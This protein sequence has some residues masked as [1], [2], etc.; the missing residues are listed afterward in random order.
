MLIGETEFEAEHAA[1]IHSHLQRRSGERRGRLERGHQHAEQLFVRNAW[2]ALTNN[3]K[4][5]H[6]EYEIVDWRG[7]SYFI[8][9]VWLPGYIKLAIEI[10]GFGPHVTEMDRKRYSEELNRETF[11]RAMGFHVI[12]FSYD[13]VAQRPDLCITLLR[14]VMSRYQPLRTT[15]KLGNLAHKEIMLLSCR[16]SGIVRPKDVEEHLG[17]N[18]RTSL[19]FIHELCDKGWLRPQLNGKSNVR[20]LKYELIRQRLEYYE[21]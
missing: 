19:R 18:H 21:W 16:C 20:V 10:K 13:D 4:D 17:V 3:L 12:S 1:W 14:L 6:P 15:V 5:L 8:D 2:W 11:L 9:M 7:R